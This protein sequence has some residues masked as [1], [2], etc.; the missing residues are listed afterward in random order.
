MTRILIAG[1]LSLISIKLDAQTIGDKLYIYK[2][3]G[4]LSDDSFKFLKNISQAHFD[5]ETGKL[6]WGKYDEIDV[7]YLT[8]VLKKEFQVIEILP[9]SQVIIQSKTEREFFGKTEV[10]YSRYIISD[11]KEAMRL[12]EIVFC[13][14]HN[15]WIKTKFGEK[16]YNS[17]KENKYWIGMTEE[18]LYLSLGKPN[19]INRTV[20]SSRTRKQYVYQ[21]Y[22][23]YLYIEN[24]KVVS[25]QD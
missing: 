18:Q 1:I 6:K 2:P 8:D 9:D 20:T 21:N 25:F 17:I 22:G 12:K 14:S 7:V 15:N 3:N 24:N 11:F 19:S 4:E 10:D 23:I 16:V 13:N 5:S